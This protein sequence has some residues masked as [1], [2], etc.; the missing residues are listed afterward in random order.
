MCHALKVISKDPLPNSRSHKFSPIFSFIIFI[1]LNFTFNFIIHF[2]L[3]LGIAVRS[4]FNFFFCYHFLKGKL[5]LHWSFLCFCLKA[6]DRMCVSLFLGYFVPVIHL[7]VLRPVHHYL[8]YCSFI[9]KS[10][11]QEM[12]VIQFC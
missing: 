4:A 10:G 3:I 7:S 6:V 12:P 2:M 9:I 1:D 11:H 5:F 8:N